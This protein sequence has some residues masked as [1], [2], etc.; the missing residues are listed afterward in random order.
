M[1]AVLAVGVFTVSYVL[2][3]TER[4]SKV[5]AA[6]GGAAVVVA[7][8]IVGSEDVFYSHKTGID[9]DVIFLL[10]G[11]MVIVGVLR[12]T[13]VFEYTAIWATKRAGGSALRVMVLLV[14]ITALA[15]AL[16]DNVT[17]VL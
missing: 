5:K 9:W 10:L 16:L 6:L 15:S 14:L 3:A 11:M 1:T 7:L 12:Q 13:G 8:G 17:T 2:I 4:I